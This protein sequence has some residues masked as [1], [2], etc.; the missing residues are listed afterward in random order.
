MRPATMPGR[1]PAMNRSPID[2]SVAIPYTISGID[3]GIRMPSEPD[4]AIRPVENRLP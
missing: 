2:S 1:T 4:V 3:G